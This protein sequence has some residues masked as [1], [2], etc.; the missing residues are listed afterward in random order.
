MEFSILLLYLCS[1]SAIPDALSPFQK[2]ILKQQ[3]K[4]TESLYI[5][6]TKHHINFFEIDFVFFFH[7]KMKCLLQEN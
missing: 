3:P 6:S 2:I 5:L 7:I 4:Y 1:T